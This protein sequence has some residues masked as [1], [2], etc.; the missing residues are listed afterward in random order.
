MGINDLVNF[1]F[2]DPPVEDTMIRSLSQLYALGAL[3]DRAELTKLGRRMAE[4]PIDP[5]M[6]KAIVA[7]EKYECTDEVVS[8]CAMLSEQS[9]LLYRPKD[10]KILADT[11][12]QNLVKPGGDHLTLLNIWNQWVETDYSVQ[13]CYENFIQVKTMER[14]RNVRDQ[15]VQLLD[16]VEVK[17]VS[18]PN[19]NDPTPIQK[20]KR[21]LLY[22][23][24]NQSL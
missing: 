12:H 8:I 16:R 10:K 5:C 13:W 9:S 14:V 22:I 3:N 17:L 19:P 23:I 20:V 6:S 11:A 24:T 18:N 1:D 7:S 15:L 21:W 2:L 4:F